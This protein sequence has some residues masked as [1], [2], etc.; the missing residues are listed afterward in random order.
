MLSF[1]VVL[2]RMILLLAIGVVATRITIDVIGL[3]LYSVYTSIYGMVFFFTFIQTAIQSASNVIHSDFIKSDL[4]QNNYLG[5][6]LP[7]T[8]IFYFL[9]C[10][11]LYFILVNAISIFDISINS[12][13]LNAVIL[14]IFCI[15]ILSGTSSLLMNYLVILN[16]NKQ[17]LMISFLETLIKASGLLL[18]YFLDLNNLVDYALLLFYTQMFFTLFVFLYLK[19]ITSFKTKFCLENFKKFFLL[20]FSLSGE[21]ISYS[22][23]GYG[24]STMLV[25][26]F[27]TQI[28]AIRNIAIQMTIIPSSLVSAFYSAIM[29]KMFGSDRSFLINIKDLQLAKFIFTILIFFTLPLLILSNQLLVLW[30][31]TKFPI[32]ITVD[33]IEVLF[34]SIYLD[35]AF[36]NLR[37][38]IDLSNKYNSYHK[39]LVYL[40]ISYI[41][42]LALFLYMFHS[43]Q[44]ALYSFVLFTILVSFLRYR[45]LYNLCYSSKEQVYLMKYYI[46]VNVISLSLFYFLES[47]ISRNLYFSF[48]FSIVYYLFILFIL[49]DKKDRSFLCNSFYNLFY[50]LIRKR[51]F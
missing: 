17:H 24:F 13:D 1:S 49:N 6:V 14:L 9:F 2:F 25:K 11:P 51:T 29:P 28:G 12:I 33:F 10:I 19:F 8:M 20:V 50:V 37:A 46:L 34:I 5:I 38:N 3:E 15:Y 36:L 16:K 45:Y 4:N 22:I 35:S 39:S 23:N 43:I 31:G 40:S 26:F 32:A 44:F 7:N 42:I 30:L 27:G 47:N 41:I 48:L 21:H 18:L